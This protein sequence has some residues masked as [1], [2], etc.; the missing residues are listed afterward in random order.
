MKLPNLKFELPK[1][2]FELLD[3]TNPDDIEDEK[4]YDVYTLDKDLKLW[5]CKGEIRKFKI[6]KSDTSW[7]YQKYVLNIYPEPEPQWFTLNLELAEKVSLELRYIW[8]KQLE[9]EVR[10]IKETPDEVK[11]ICKNFFIENSKIIKE[12]FIMSESGSGISYG[13]V[14]KRDC[15][16]NRGKI[17]QLFDRVSW[18]ARGGVY[19]QFIPTKLR[20]KIE[21]QELIE[22][23]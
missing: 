10:I 1:D 13:V 9:D 11:R 12:V 2:Y 4:V 5:Y 6:F 23:R 7:R 22:L 18:E 20:S 14:L 16:K 21:A 3:K 15:N 19:L 8:R 17:H